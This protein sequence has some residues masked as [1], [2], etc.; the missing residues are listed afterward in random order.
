MYKSQSACPATP[1]AQWSFMLLTVE[2]RKDLVIAAMKAVNS[3]VE[4]YIMEAYFLKLSNQSGH[5]SIEVLRDKFIL[6][7]FKKLKHRSFVTIFNCTYSV[8]QTQG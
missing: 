6:Q 2:N 5:S 4:I 8:C 3:N 7:V 1:D